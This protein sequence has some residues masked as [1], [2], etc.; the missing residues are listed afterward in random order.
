MSKYSHL[1]CTNTL[2]REV[3]I[4]RKAVIA[5][6]TFPLTKK[7]ANALG[8]PELPEQTRGWTPENNTIKA[9]LIELKP[10]N[11]DLFSELATTV[12]C[13]AITDL[14]V[15]RKEDKNGKDSVK[16]KSRIT[17]V[18]CSVT[19]SEEA[20][21]AKLEQYMKAKRSEMRITY[22]PTPEGEGERVDMTPESSQLPLAT[23]E[24]QEAV[25]EIEAEPVER[26]RGRPRKDVQ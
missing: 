8:W 26:K 22:D 18:S 3:K 11:D 7:V 17:E 13:S 5:K 14:S 23:A 21:A 2:L 9:S 6:F 16:A 1:T 19:I 15:I 20:G 24:Q 25:A 4:T 12:E 10:N